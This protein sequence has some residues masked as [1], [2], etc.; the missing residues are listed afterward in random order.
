MRK[1]KR[2]LEKENLN[3]LIL[4]FDIFETTKVKLQFILHRINIR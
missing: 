4:S 1:Y 2:P 3:I